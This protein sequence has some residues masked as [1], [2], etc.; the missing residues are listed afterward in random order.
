MREERFGYTRWQP[1]GE[2]KIMDRDGV[3]REMQMDMW[4]YRM[5]TGETRTI[6]RENDEVAALVLYG[7]VTLGWDGQ[8]AVIERHSFMDEGLTCL[9]VCRDTTFTIEAHADSE[10]IFVATGNE[11][12]F[13]PKL[14]TPD[15]TRENE[16]CM[17]LWGGKAERLVRT[18]FEYA[19]APY[20]NLVLGETIMYEGCWSGYIPH[21]HPQPEVYYFR[22]EKPSA[23]GASFVGDEVF[24]I[25]DGSFCAI[26]K[27]LPHPQAAAPGYRIYILWVIR[28]LDGD[29]WVREACSDEEVH[30]WLKP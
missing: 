27:N 23:F 9:H 16:S 18:A 11:R 20:S 29:P 25:T 22:T 2:G 1:D 15:N 8:A 19:D 3:Y 6:R 4:A 26:G 7:K 28:H 17:G 30:K 10:V 5:K 13:A 21:Y 14:Y 24:K 12:A